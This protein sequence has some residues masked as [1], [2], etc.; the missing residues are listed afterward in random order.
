MIFNIGYLILITALILSAYG[1]VIGFLG[2]R[3]RNSKFAASAASTIYASASL[4][5]AAALI[6]WYGL[7][8]DS[9][10]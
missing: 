10:R 1:V 6:L 8:T 9:F 7:F 3:T 2:G 5:I 4:V